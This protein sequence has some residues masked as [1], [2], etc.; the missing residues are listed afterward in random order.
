L[1]SMM[2]VTEYMFRN[3]DALDNEIN[4]F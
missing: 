2:I 3:D 4:A 1:L